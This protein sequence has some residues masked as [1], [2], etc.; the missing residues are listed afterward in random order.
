MAI[1]KKEPTA[2]KILKGNPCRRPLPAGEPIPEVTE[3]VP[4]APSHIKGSA[5]K[6]WKYISRKLHRLGLLTEIDVKA[7]ALYCQA[8]GRWA[9]AQAVVNE[10]GLTVTSPSG[11][12][13]QSPHVGIANKA[14]ADCFKYLTSFGMT[15]SSRTGVT[16]AEKG[17]KSKFTGLISGTGKT[18]K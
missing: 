4:S 1:P 18:K 8:Y 14:M 12:V 6:E 5:L 15:P 17:K 11:Y 2:L 13:I 9:D 7:L 10:E 3:R 16:T